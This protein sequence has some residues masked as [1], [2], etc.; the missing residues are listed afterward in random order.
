MHVPPPAPP[1][2]PV[3]VIAPLILSCL[4]GVCMSHAAYMLRDA[5]SA[6]LF[7]IVGILCK[8]CGLSTVVP[9]PSP[10]HT[11]PPETRPPAADSGGTIL[12]IMC[13]QSL[14]PPTGGDGYH[15]PHDLGQACWARGH[16][17]AGHVVRN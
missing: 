5:V 7:T 2:P 16:C 10:I 15:Q 11:M 14:P 8:V 12:L 6:T 3:Q 13:P 1:P 4:V 17:A 9:G